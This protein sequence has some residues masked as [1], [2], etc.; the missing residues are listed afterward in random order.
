MPK[1]SKRAEAS[2]RNGAKSRGPVTE[3][4]K[5]ISRTN[6]LSHG[7]YSSTPLIEVEFYQESPTKFKRLVQSLADVYKPQNALEEHFVFEAATILLKIQRFRAYE[8]TSL[9]DLAD[10]SAFMAKRELAD[11]KRKLDESEITLK[12]FTHHADIV[13][14]WLADFKEE[15]I[16]PNNRAAILGDLEEALDQA[17]RQTAHEA[18]S[19]SEELSRI[20]SIKELDLPNQL[21]LFSKLRQEQCVTLLSTIVTVKRHIREKRREITRQ[22]QESLLPSEQTEGRLAREEFLQKS[23]DLVIARLIRH[24]QF[25]SKA[26]K[27]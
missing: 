14:H 20:G 7:L 18:G 9:Q 3:D 6:R 17:T 1:T 12:Q 23:F 5:N 22:V 16:D 21:R 4:G 24:Q 15:A 2:R 10:K 8:R 13:N 19:L 25:R 26:T 11:L 27:P